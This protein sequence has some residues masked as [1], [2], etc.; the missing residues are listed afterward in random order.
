[1]KKSM[2]KSFFWT[3]GLVLQMSESVNFLSF[4]FSY[5]ICLMGD[6]WNGVDQELGVEGGG[7]LEGV[8]ETLLG[9]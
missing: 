2:A 4:F 8:P 5:V 3:G 9:R 6:Q 7:S 1:M